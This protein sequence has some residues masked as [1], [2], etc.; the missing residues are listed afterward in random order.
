MGTMLTVRLEFHVL[1][2]SE[3]CHT[4]TQIWWFFYCKTKTRMFSNRWEWQGSFVIARKHM[5][6]NARSNHAF[7]KTVLSKS[8]L[9]GSAGVPCAP[10]LVT[11]AHLL[12]SAQP[13]SSSPQNQPCSFRPLGATWRCKYTCLITHQTYKNK[14]NASFLTVENKWKKP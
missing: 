12:C 6:P 7:I 8:G 3:V 4:T 9:I 13:L 10:F 11:V 1:K 2:E 14:S 5:I